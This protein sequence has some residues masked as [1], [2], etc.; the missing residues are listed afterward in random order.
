MKAYYKKNAIQFIYS[1]CSI[2]ISLI[3]INNFLTATIGT[4]PM[5]ITYVNKDLIIRNTA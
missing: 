4:K 5:F 3:R 1:V 2:L